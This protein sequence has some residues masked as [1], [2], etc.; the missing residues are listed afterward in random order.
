MRGSEQVLLAA[1]VVAL[2]GVSLFA[3]YIEF[4]P[5]TTTSSSDTTTP[6]SSTLK[7][8]RSV[9]GTSE[10]ASNTFISSTI[11]VPCTGQGQGVVELLVV[12]D[13][14]GAPVIGESINAVNNLSCGENEQQVVYVN[15]FTVGQ[16]GW[17][18]PILPNQAAPYGWLNFTVTYQG[19]IYHF[20]AKYPVFFGKECVTLHVPSG[21][22]TT[23]A[24]AAGV[25]SE[26]NQPK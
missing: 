22:V 19:A 9:T 24:M 2:L 4:T 26:T 8:A 11:L 18:T 6:N 10:S 17:L 25:C 20:P 13:S 3:Y 7:S 15:N 16:G 14:T 1:F 23:T 21:N 5:R 12:S